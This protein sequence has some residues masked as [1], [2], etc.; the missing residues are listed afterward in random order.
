MGGAA[1][2]TLAQVGAFV[3][4]YAWGA[5]RDATGGFRAGLFLLFAMGVATC[6]LLA[7]ICRQLR[8]PAPAAAPA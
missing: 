5:L 7:W 3:A 2:N 6:L 8:V 1:I 4:P